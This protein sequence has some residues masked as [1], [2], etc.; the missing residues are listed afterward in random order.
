MLER[1]P[2]ARKSRSAIS[3]LVLPENTCYPGVIPSGFCF[4]LSS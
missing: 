2:S 4:R 1:P 3:G